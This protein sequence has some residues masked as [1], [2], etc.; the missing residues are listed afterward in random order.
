V[1]ALEAR[2]K[3]TPQVADTAASAAQHFE[4]SGGPHA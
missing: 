3:A 4:Q 1:E 2:L